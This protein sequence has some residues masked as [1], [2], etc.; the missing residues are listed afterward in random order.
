MSLDLEVVIGLEV[1]VQ[2]ATRSKLFCACPAEFGA[3][4]NRNVCAV[5]TGQPGALPVLNAEALSLAIRAGLA[6]DCAI[7]PR[8][9]FERKNYFYPDLPKGYQIS[10][11]AEPIDHDGHVVIEGDDGAPRQIAIVRAHLEEDAGK[12]MH[13]PGRRDSLVDFNRAGVPLLEIVTGPVLRSPGEAHRYLD[14]LKRRLRYARVSECDMEKGSLRCDANLSLRPRGE[15]RLGRRVEIK[16]LNSF[17]NVERALAFEIERQTAMLARGEIVAQETRGFVDVDGTTIPLRSKEDSEDYRYFPDPDLPVFA[18][19]AETIEAARAALP[20]LD[21][22]KAV[23]YRHAL[24]LGDA[25]VAALIADRDVAEYFDRG[26]AT[27]SGATAAGL[28]NFVLGSALALANERGVPLDEIAIPPAALAD[29]AARVE[30]GEISVQA[31]RMRVLPE[32][33]AS[34]R[35]P[36]EVIAALSLVQVS[37]AASIDAFC[38]QA[39]AALPKAVAEYRAGKAAALN[40][41]VGSVMKASGGKA[42]PNLARERL[43]ALLAE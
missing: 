34:G 27:N 11:F 36:S 6:L 20:E 17:R 24:G 21:V 33:A 4:P 23:R 43:A 35:T 42:N 7:A 16:N 28:A 8:T 22:A 19:A 40:S 26:V 10:Q 12:T 38:Q 15:S 41:L 18:V 14:A 1:H 31:A 39:I 37:D 2:L 29:V 5:C 9:R 3:T 30:K 13:P 32:I 25:V